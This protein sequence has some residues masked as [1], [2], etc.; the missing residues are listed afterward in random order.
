MATRD[1]RRPCIQ[2]AVLRSRGNPLNR[3]TDKRYHFEV[4][5]RHSWL[6]PGPV[7]R[8]RT[9]MGAWSQV[10]NV[11]LLAV[12]D[13]KLWKCEHSSVYYRQ[14]C[15]RKGNDISVVDCFVYLWRH[16]LGVP[17]VGE[18]ELNKNGHDSIQ[19]GSIAYSLTNLPFIDTGHNQN[20]K[21]WKK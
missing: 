8:A 21:F 10:T 5:S 13:S 7:P 1:T 15:L 4:V 14:V 12:R 6:T 9:E 19:S 11:N 2:W 18:I 20:L 3:V 16:L 17:G